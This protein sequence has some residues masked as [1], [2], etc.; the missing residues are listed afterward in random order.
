[1]IR[2]CARRTLNK[3]ILIFA[4][5]PL[6]VILRFSY[7]QVA[8]RLSTDSILNPFL[9][10]L[11][12]SSASKISPD[13]GIIFLEMT[14]NK[15]RLDW[16]TYCALESASRQNPSRQIYY[17]I[18]KNN[19]HDYK[20]L[21]FLMGLGNIQVG[22]FDFQTLIRDYYGSDVLHMFLNANIDVYSWS[23]LCRCLLLHQKGGVYM[24]VDTISVNQI[25]NYFPNILQRNIKK[26]LTNCFMKFEAGHPFLKIILEDLKSK[27][28]SN[29]VTAMDG[30]LVRDAAMR[31][32]RYV[33]VGRKPNGTYV[34]PHHWRLQIFS[35]E[36]KAVAHFLNW[37]NRKQVW[38]STERE[39]Y[40]KLF[41]LH[42][43]TVQK[44]RMY[45]TAG[46]SELYPK[47]F[48]LHLSTVQNSHFNQPCTLMRNY[49][50]LPNIMEAFCPRTY[51]YVFNLNLTNACSIN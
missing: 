40:P 42:L 28:L 30:P 34:C 35:R 16:F 37:A 26:L 29:N 41:A 2:I 50:G 38:N 14:T 3:I 45:G 51:S 5:F 15:D 13:N 19:Q 31:H 17:L 44:R 25:P 11:H 23:D 22:K 24:D 6:L 33:V 20:V 12:I 49:P 36:E 47:L 1:M 7:N 48:A 18:S 21:S 9:T 39:L 27:I 4:I 43:S 10:K 8:T 32:C 46:L